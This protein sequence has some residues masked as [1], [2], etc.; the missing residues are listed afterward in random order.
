MLKQATSRRIA[1]GAALLVLGALLSCQ[2]GAD[3]A[4]AKRTP[5][6]PP[7]ESSA[8]PDVSI[9]VEVDGAAAAAIDAARLEATPPDFAEEDRRVWKLSTLL[10][11]KA[12]RPGTL[13]AVGGS[14]GPEVVLRIP[15]KADDPQPALLAR[16]RGEVVATMVSPREPFPGYHGRGGR[17]GR[18]GDTVPRIVGV[19]YIRV[20]HEQ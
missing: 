16:R 7:P 5:K 18:S 15:E 20:T 10:G 17:L 1:R 4:E 3:L 6:P 14:E 13:V 9:T 19:R 2:D 8:V 12:G 11:E